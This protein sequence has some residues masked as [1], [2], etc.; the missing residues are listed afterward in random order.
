MCSH[1][2]VAANLQT[3]DRAATHGIKCEF[4]RKTNIEDGRRRQLAALTC[5]V[6]NNG[7]TVPKRPDEAG[8][9]SYFSLE[10]GKKKPQKTTPSFSSV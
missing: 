5:V 9:A 7:D 2:T 3:K 4:S 8:D 1:D 6:F 10:N